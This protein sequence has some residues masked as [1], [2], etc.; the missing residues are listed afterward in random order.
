[1][2]NAYV[3]Q[4]ERS[5]D[6]RDLVEKALVAIAILVSWEVAVWAFNVPS[7]LV[8]P[9]SD[10]AHA[11][12][13][14]VSSGLYFYHA[15]FTLGATLLGFMLGSTLGFVIGVLV[16]Q[17]PVLD[18]LVYP[19]VVAFQT[20]PK[21]ALAP[22]IVVW[23]GFGIGSKVVMSM[24]IC[25]F[26]VVV[27]T[28]EGQH[29]APSEQIMLLRSYKA[30]RLQI[31]WIVQLPASLPFVFAGLNIGIILSVIGTIVGE[32]VGTTAGLGYILLDFNQS[33][34]IAGVFGTLIVLS[35]VGV[36]LHKILRSIQKRV[37]FWH[38]PGTTIGA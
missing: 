7:Y 37:V 5:F 22:L 31:F 38:K 24:L 17:V 4:K 11:F 9:P 3:Q 27:N 34:D 1:M 14:G 6:P 8:P 16:A 19:Y 29:S 23:F 2:T 18:R 28:I 21:V 10:V 13:L 25:F 32:F 20:V 15:Q 33:F 35:L 36:S 30:S 12:W 26:P